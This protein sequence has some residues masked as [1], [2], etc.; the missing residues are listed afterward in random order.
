MKLPFK[1]LNLESGMYQDALTRLNT[2]GDS[3]PISFTELLEELDPSGN[4]PG[5]NLDAF[6]RQLAARGLVVHG[7]RSITLAEFYDPANIVLFPEFI[8]REVR[9]GM[10][11]GPNQLMVSDMIG[12]S[13]EIDSG[14]YDA[15]YLNEAEVKDNAKIGEGA[16]F[17]VFDI[18]TDNKSIKLGKTGFMLRETYEHRRRIRVNK[19]A[20]FIRHQARQMEKA[21]VEVGLDVSIN[22]NTGNNNAA[23][24]HAATGLNYNNMVDFWGE[25]DPYA[26]DL[27][28]ADKAGIL[29]TLKLSEFKDPE[30]GFNFQRTGQMV[31]PVGNMLKRHDSTLLADKVLGMDSNMALELVTERGSNIVE[32][33]AVIRNQTNEIAVSEVFGFARMFAPAAGVWDYS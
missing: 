30:A 5:C 10:V 1:K 24:S 17:P 4:H 27:L 8:V 26:S 3:A 16:D 6:Q 19:L 9:A 33:E 25:F 13:T 2:Q 11:L 7:P 22:G 21:R 23:F 15:A 28:A 20:V 14:V 29:A 18:K 32:A 12:L 31:T